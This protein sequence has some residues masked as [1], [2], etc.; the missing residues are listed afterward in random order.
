MTEL[1]VASIIGAALF[2]GAGLFAARRGRHGLAARM[3]LER[4]VA[5]QR[6]AAGTSEATTLRT[7]LAGVQAELA[8]ALDAEQTGAAEREAARMARQRLEAHLAAARADA[9]HHSDDARRLAAELG[10]ARAGAEREREQAAQTI[11]QTQ[12]ESARTQA[13]AA[14]TLEAARAERRASAGGSQVQRLHSVRPYIENSVVEG[15]SSCR[16]R[17]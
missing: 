16:R 9:A 4:A 17:M 8:R 7:E 10:A 11:R 13:E 1:W 12:A 5:E 2:F 14:R 3:A 15:N 6:L